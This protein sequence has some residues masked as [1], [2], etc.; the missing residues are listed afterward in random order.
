MADKEIGVLLVVEGETLVGIFSERDYA[1][2]V[3]LKGK[4]SKETSVG[5]LMTREV[6]YV[7]PS[8]T[9]EECMALMTGKCL[10]FMTLCYTHR[11]IPYLDRRKIT[12]LKK[13]FYAMSVESKYG[14]A[15]TETLF[16]FMYVPEYE[17][18][19][20]LSAPTEI[21]L[22]NSSVKMRNLRTLGIFLSII[23]IV[24]WASLKGASNV[25]GKLF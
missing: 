2:K 23:G 1:R 14:L 17:T 11:S 7:D 18:V 19:T 22:S 20:N 15:R 9:M 16:D 8:T 12:S 24:T 21:K 6:Y 10:F 5:E 4:S 13:I 25:V 3:I